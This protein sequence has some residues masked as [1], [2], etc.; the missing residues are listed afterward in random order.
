MP[1][2][3]KR[4]LILCE[5][6]TDY[7]F[8]RGYLRERYKASQVDRVDIPYG[9]GSAEAHVRRRLPAEIRARRSRRADENLWLVVVTDAD[10]TEIADRL[11]T[12]DQAIKDANLKPRTARERVLFLIPKRNIEAWI[13][14]AHGNELEET[15]DFKHRYSSPRASHDGKRAAQRCV[16]APAGEMS[17]SLAHACEELRRIV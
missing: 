15:E 8:V 2:A 14:W 5:G 4:F 6:Q 13:H 7:Q 9:L 1:E 3:R 10:T 12:L 16:Q 17:G 11:Q